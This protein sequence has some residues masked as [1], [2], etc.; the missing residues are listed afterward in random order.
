MKAAVLTGIR[1]MEVR[2]IPDP[3]LR[4]DTDV[5]LRIRRVGVCGSD[6][7]YYTQGRIGSQVV[8]YPFPVGH[9]CSAEVVKVGLAVEPAMSCGRCDQCRAGRPHTCRAI[10]FLGCPG[11]ADGC[12]G[13]RLV[14]PEDCCF[15]VQASTSLELAALVEPM[16]ISVYGVQQAGAMGPDTRLAILGAGPIGLCAL[17]AARA[18]GARTLYVTDRIE[19]RLAVARRCGAAWAG[20]PDRE[21]VVAAIFEREPLGLDVVLECCGQQAALDQAVSLLKPGGRLVLVGI[22][23]VDRISFAIDQMRR[24][25][26]TLQNI[27]RQNHCVEPALAL[28]ETGAVDVS[29]L[30]THR[31][32]LERTKEAFDL[33][34]DYRDGVV[35]AMIE[36]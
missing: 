22:P 3:V 18:A 36:I 27:R 32:P 13:E 20:N 21:D 16:S 10:R 31:F 8:Q 29:P 6:V 1:Q 30:V 15:P 5:L 33:V 35:K 28:I 7:H 24:K 26:I 4:A 17:L 9:E 19:A 23:E 12:I 25:E 14:M 2:E 34:A 11:Q